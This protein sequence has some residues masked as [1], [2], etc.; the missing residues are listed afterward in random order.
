MLLILLGIPDFGLGN[1]EFYFGEFSIFDK[2]IL[3]LGFGNSRFSNSRFRF[4]NSRIIY[5]KNN[6]KTTF[7]YICV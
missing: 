3:D 5:L 7:V 1:P 6:L 2:G 4:R